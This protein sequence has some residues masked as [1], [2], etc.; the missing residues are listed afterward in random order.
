MMLILTEQSFNSS[1]SST[2]NTNLEK[3]RMLELFQ[4]QVVFLKPM[5]AKQDLL[6]R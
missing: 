1:L 5:G 6:S 3:I 4:D 2:K